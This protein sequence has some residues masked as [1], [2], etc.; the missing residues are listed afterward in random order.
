MEPP[1]TASSLSIPKRSISLR[2]SRT[3]SPIVIGGSDIAYGQPVSG[4]IEPGPVVPRHPPST[5]E[6]ITKY[7]SVSNA[8][9]GPIIGSHQPSCPVSLSVPA[10]CASPEKACSTRMALVREAFSS[11][12]VS[13][14]TSTGAMVSPVSSS[15]DGNC[16]YCISE[17][18]YGGHLNCYHSPRL[19]RDR[20]DSHPRAV[21]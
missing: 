21:P 12:Y 19:S 2:C 3:M 5:L 11:P 7:L 1:E 4:S 10:A 9:P 17:V 20:R 8:L 13:Y 15:I 16:A 14:A 18:I 6:Q